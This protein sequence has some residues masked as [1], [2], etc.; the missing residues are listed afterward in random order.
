M[1]YLSLYDV[2]KGCKISED[3]HFDLNNPMVRNLLIKSK[4][5]QD[6]VN[7]KGIG[8]K[9]FPLSLAGVPEEW[10]AYPKQVGSFNF[11]FIQ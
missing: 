6:D 1:S 5:K 8:I 7:N 4:K 2:Q 11:F 9:A 3:F 10:L